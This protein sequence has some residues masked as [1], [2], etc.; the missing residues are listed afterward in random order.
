MNGPA[1]GRVV[2]RA[3]VGRALALAL[4][5]VAGVRRVE[6]SLRSTLRSWGRGGGGGVVDTL[7]V[8]YRGESAD[9]QVDIATDTTR[10]AI[11]VAGDVQRRAREILVDHGLVPGRVEVAVLTVEA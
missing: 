1:A 6:P 5:Q 4:A 7:P 8:K 2:S 10:P 3:E 11:E 9:L